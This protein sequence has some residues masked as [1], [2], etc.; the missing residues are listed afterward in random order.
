MHGKVMDIE[1]NNAKEG[2]AVIAYQKNKDARNQ[3]W[4]LD[5][6][7]LLRSALNDFVPCAS[8]SFC[9]FQYH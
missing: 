4:Y 5:E 2:A 1:R 9:H 7:G 6:E 8:G 3:M